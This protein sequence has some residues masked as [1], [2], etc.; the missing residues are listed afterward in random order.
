M[1]SKGDWGLWLLLGGGTVVTLALAMRSAVAQAAEEEDVMAEAVVAGALLQ[2][3]LA[4]IKITSGFGNR[5]DPITGQP[6]SW[7]PGLDLDADFMQPVHASEA[8]IVTRAQ[9]WYG[10]G[11]QVVVDHGTI[12]GKKLETSYS[13][14]TQ[15]YV[16]KG[17]LVE[18]GEV[19]GG[20][21]STGRSTGVHLHFEVHAN[22]TAVNP[23]G[24]L[25]L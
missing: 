18:G 23:K 24:Y 14:L 25:G 8:G 9:E 5:I 22:G 19:L 6:G 15:I 21:G 7:H 16:H 12:G 2:P 13:H 1:A 4:P 3:P 10:Y 20:A 11:N 17:D